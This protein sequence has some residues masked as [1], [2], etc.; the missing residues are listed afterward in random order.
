MID[1]YNRTIDYLRISI[2]D[3]CDLRCVYCMPSTG[4]QKRTHKE[5]LRIS[6]ILEIVEAAASLGIRKIRLTG[7]EPLCRKG[8]LSLCEGISSVAGIEELTLTTNGNLL[9]A[10]ATDLKKA[11]VHRINIS[12]DSLIPEKYHSITRRGNLDTV[13]KGIHAAKEA[14]LTPIKMNT[15]LI[16]GFNDDEISQ[17]VEL[18][19]TEPIDVRFIELMPI[20]EASKAWQSGFLPISTVLER[21]PNLLPISNKNDGVATLYRLPDGVGKVGLISPVSNHFC[22]SC[23]RIRLTPDGKIKPCLHAS[24]EYNIRGYH[25]DNLRQRLEKIIFLKPTGHLGLSNE[26]PSFAGRNMNEIGG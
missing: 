24:N 21:V 5:I 23:N 7:G 18:T 20:G 4:V 15:V 22:N 8:L 13:L 1:Q 14:G 10:F 16:G 25:G 6:E 2:T 11:G 9:F 17:F 3:L 19:K 26:Q 12:L